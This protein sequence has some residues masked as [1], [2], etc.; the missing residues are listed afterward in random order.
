MGLFFLDL[1]DVTQT[2]AGNLE[3]SLVHSGL[4]RLLLSYPAH[5]RK[6]EDVMGLG[7]AAIELAREAGDF[8]AEVMV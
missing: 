2:M 1:G 7:L 6:S 5:N 4:A 8:Q 3:M